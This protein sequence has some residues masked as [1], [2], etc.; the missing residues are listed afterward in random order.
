MK[1]L[2]MAS[3]CRA[4]PA[5]SQA[6]VIHNRRRVFVT[7]IATWWGSENTASQEPKRETRSSSSSVPVPKP[8]IGGFTPLLLGKTE[9]M[10]EGSPTCYF[11]GHPS[12]SQDER[13]VM[14]A[15]IDL[16]CLGHIYAKKGLVFV[17][18][19]N[20]TGFPVVLLC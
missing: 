18:N 2:N 3:S 19:A 16:A 1:L 14:Q 10:E 11:Q 12:I 20:L 4:L 15:G 17:W 6:E 5:R 13:G 9:S 7:E 8:H